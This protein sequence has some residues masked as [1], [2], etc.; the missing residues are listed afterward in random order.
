MLV[1]ENQL[2]TEVRQN[3]RGGDGQS[4]LNLVP[5]GM[6]PKGTR[7]C[8]VIELESGCSIGSHTHDKETEVFHFIC[9][10]GEVDDNGEVKA[11]SAGDTMMTGGG[12]THSVRNTGSETL[13]FFAIIILN[14]E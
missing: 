4:K 5:E 9:G 1:K 3:M 12:G 7:L 13:R 8:S 11:V 14:A 2:N 10:S 6:L